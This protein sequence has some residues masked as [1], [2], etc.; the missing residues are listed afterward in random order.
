M[1]QL[2][3]LRDSVME[4]LS[5]AK[6]RHSL[7]LATPSHDP[8][9]MQRPIQ[10][11][12]EPRN[13]KGKAIIAGRVSKKYLSPSDTKRSVRKLRSGTDSDVEYVD[14]LEDGQS[15]VTRVS[16]K[17]ITPEDS[18]SQVRAP[19]D[20]GSGISVPTQEEED[21]DSP[22]DLDLDSEEES[23][24]DAEAKVHQFLDRQTELARRQE[25]LE[26]IKEGDW[27]K[28]EITLFQKLSLRG[29]EP[30][31]PAH[32]SFDFRTCPSTIFSDKKEET[33]INSQSG[34]EFRAT[35]ALSSLVTLG[36]RVRALLE[37]HKP[38]EQLIK[39]ELE[40]YIKWSERDGGY[41]NKRFI[42]LLCLV[43]G[44]P[45]Q[46]LP[47]L[48]KH[49]TDQLE[50]LA[51][52]HR[53]ALALPPPGRLNGLGEVEIFSRPPPVVY[54]VIIAH[55]VTVFVTLDSGK[56]DAKPKTIA[57]FD[58]SN[59]DMDVWNGF[60]LAILVCMVRNQL[61]AIIDEMESDHE[62]GGIDPDL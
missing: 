54:G 26:R 48:V 62:D 35:N 37:C 52:K 34:N 16:R 12:T 45:T 18:S 24:L 13:R 51:M 3:K 29:L 14:G 25:A 50:F 46:E 20:D 40:N 6:R 61:M 5:P 17:V 59:K 43:T 4:Y 23:E 57:H 22:D 42:P 38:Q 39:K 41:T 10:P 32:W 30:L 56:I 11:T 55:C 60:A 49:I 27:H 19:S 31:L 1:E 9:Q 8:A 21:H 44:N 58:F 53:Q 47:V 28:D 2:F 33:F 36:G 7:L 15:S